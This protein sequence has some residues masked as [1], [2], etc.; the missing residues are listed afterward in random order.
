MR[1]P[2]GPLWTCRTCAGAAV[3]S[4]VLRRYLTGQTAK[5]LWRTAVT[6][7]V[8]SP[9]PCPSCGRALREFAASGDGRRVN[10]DLC[11]ICQLMWFDRNELEAFPKAPDVRPAEVERN[12]ELAK[13]QFEANLEDRERSPEDIVAQAMGIIILIIRL[14]LFR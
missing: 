8:P 1:V 14:L 12:L 6:R 4:A 2:A 10:L 11:K 3:T 7:S 9:R 5:E 13:L